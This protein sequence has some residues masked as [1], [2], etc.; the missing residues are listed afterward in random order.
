MN[1]LLG[2]ETPFV[3]SLSKDRAE[4][5]EAHT[6]QSTGQVIALVGAEC[7]G[8][9]QLSRALQEALASPAQRVAL[10]P[11]YL[12]E[13]CDASG[14][15]P[16]RVEQA[17]IAD[18][19][20]RR[21]TEALQ[22]HDLVIAD[23][24][25]LMTA[26]YSDY[27]FQDASLYPSAEAAHA[28]SRLT[29]LT[30]LDLPWQGDGLQR[31]G[32]HVRAPVDALVRAGLARCGAPYAVVSGLGVARVDAAL[33]SIQRALAQPPAET[34]ERPR[35]QWHCERCGESACERHS[36]LPHQG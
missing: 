18:E 11:E 12:R 31:D 3:L 33:A 10:V 17:H 5:V 29:L 20:T 4:P 26:V 22:H 8:K 36:L 14:R 1:P 24:T 35:W 28:P 32:A 9:T 19:Q 6:Q 23:T 25:A 16:Q 34:A 27:V 2:M 30:A 21:I 13:F 15:T 7:T